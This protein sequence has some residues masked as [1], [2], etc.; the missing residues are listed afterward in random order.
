MPIETM[1]FLAAYT[2]ITFEQIYFCVGLIGA[3]VYVS[4]LVM[5]GIRRWDLHNL[6]N[7]MY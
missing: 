4:K 1:H 7:S 3:C 6:L 2:L 5:S